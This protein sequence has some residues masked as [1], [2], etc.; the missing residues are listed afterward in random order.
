MTLAELQPEELKVVWLAY[1][2]WRGLFEVVAEHGVYG[3][4]PWRIEVPTAKRMVRGLVE[5]DWLAGFSQRTNK[6]DLATAI[7][8][9]ELLAAIEHDDNWLPPDQ[10]Q[11]M[12]GIR[13]TEGAARAFIGA[14]PQTST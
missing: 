5:R 10:K 13:L 2:D 12:I 3:E 14:T 11:P 9:A 1:D 7:S 8:N 6:P 4:P